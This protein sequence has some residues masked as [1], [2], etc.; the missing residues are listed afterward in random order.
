MNITV[1]NAVKNLNIWFLD[2][3]S[4]RAAPVTAKKSPNSCHPGALSVKV[5]AV[6]QSAPRPDRAAR[7]ARP[8]AVQ[9]VVNHEDID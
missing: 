8:A 3:T 6:K 1:R 2:R 4:R 7:D 9:D 5:P